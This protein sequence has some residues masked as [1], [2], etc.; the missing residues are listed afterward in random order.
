[1]KQRPLV[2]LQIRNERLKIKVWKVL[3]LQATECNRNAFENKIIERLDSSILSSGLAINFSIRRKR[4]TLYS[5]LHHPTDAASILFVQI[6]CF[7]WSRVTQ[8]L[9]SNAR[10]WSGCSRLN[11]TAPFISYSFFTKCQIEFIIHF[12][13][14]K[15]ANSFA[16][17]LNNGDTNSRTTA[18]RFRK[19]KSVHLLR[20][21]LLATAF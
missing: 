2:P 4:I 9:F 1:M 12:N 8:S 21:H 19:K 5:K 6:N 20:Q 18:R 13:S 7:I 14:V 10:V 15:Y 3:D 16:W 11:K 17:I